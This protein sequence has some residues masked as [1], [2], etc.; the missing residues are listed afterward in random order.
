M[1]NADISKPVSSRR[2][3]RTVEQIAALYPGVFT[4]SAIRALIYRAKPHYDARGQRVDGNG[5]APH[6]SRV[7]GKGGKVLI[8]ETGFA[9]WLESWTGDVRNEA[10]GH[11]E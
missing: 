6:I 10:R 7:G 8:D 1:N 5:L 3:W 4:P 11:C 2:S 9:V